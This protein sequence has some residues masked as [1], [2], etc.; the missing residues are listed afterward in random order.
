MRAEFIAYF[1][2]LLVI[3]IAQVLIDTASNRHHL[4]I[5]NKLSNASAIAVSKNHRVKTPFDYL[6]VPRRHQRQ[7]TG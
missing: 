6:F 3:P 7:K 5:G 1:L 2:A 4:I